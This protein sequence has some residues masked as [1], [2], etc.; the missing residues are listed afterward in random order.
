MLLLLQRCLKEYGGYLFIAPSFATLVQIHTVFCPR[1]A[2]KCLEE[3]LLVRVPFIPFISMIRLF[4]V[5]M[6]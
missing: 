5:Y 3:I 4:V 1:F 2:G 6:R